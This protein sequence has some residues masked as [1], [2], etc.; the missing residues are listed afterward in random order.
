MLLIY[1]NCYLVH[2]SM[3]FTHK[4]VFNIVKCVTLIISGVFRGTIALGCLITRAAEKVL[5]DI[6]CFW[7]FEIL[8]VTKISSQIK[9]L[10][11]PKRGR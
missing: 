2:F 11:S 5:D 1:Y 9:Y 10:F 8:D 3:Y 6:F 4:Y 7:S